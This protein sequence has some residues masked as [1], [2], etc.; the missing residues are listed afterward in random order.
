MAERVK[1]LSY[2]FRKALHYE[3]LR[4]KRLDDKKPSFINRKENSFRDLEHSEEYLIWFQIFKK[5]LS[6]WTVYQFVNNLEV[7]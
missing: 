3:N 2:F 1:E 4:Y 5:Y 7:T 6:H